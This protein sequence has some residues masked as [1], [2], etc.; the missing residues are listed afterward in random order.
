MNEPTIRGMYSRIRLANNVY[1]ETNAARFLTYVRLTKTEAK[2]FVARNFQEN[3]GFYVHTDSDDNLYIEG[4]D[5]A[6]EGVESTYVFD[7]QKILLGSG[8]EQIW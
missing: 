3:L 7:E 5:G 4:L 1:I 2:I 6:R 8:N